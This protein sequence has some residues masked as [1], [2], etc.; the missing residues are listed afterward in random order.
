M[1]KLLRVIMATDA[2]V[3]LALGLPLLLAP[4]FML[5]SFGYGEVP[6][7]VNFIVSIWGA[8]LLATSYAYFLAA[9]SSELM[10]WVRFGLLRNLLQAAVAL[11]FFFD[12]T[13]EL[14]QGWPGVFIPVWFALFYAIF[15]LLALREQQSPEVSSVG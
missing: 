15:R 2:V 13:I 8:V 12:G 5:Q 1:V 10:P 11:K 3:L 6:A 7:S 9:R 4:G 14:K